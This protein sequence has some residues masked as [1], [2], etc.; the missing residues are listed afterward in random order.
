MKK[1]LK[2]GFTIVE[3]VIVIAVIAILAAVLIPT[4]SNLVRKANVS[5]DTQLVRNLNTA[6]A[7]D[8]KEHKTMQSALDAAEEG[9][10]D[11][12]KIS[13]KISENKILWDSKN[14][15]FCYLN[16]GEIE[17][18]PNSVADEDKLSKDDY[19]LW[20][21]SDVVDTTYSTY[22]YG[23]TGGSTIEATKG[24]D[25]GKTEGIT[26]INYSNDGNEQKVVIRTNGGTLTVKAPL[27]TVNHYGNADK[28]DVQAVA[29]ASYHENGTVQLIAVKEG[30]VKLEGEAD[31]NGVYVYTDNASAGFEDIK[32]TVDLGVEVPKLSRSAVEIADE[33]TKVCT[34][35]TDQAKD[36]YLFNEGIYEQIKTV[37]AGKEITDSS[38]AWADSNVNTA[39]TQTAAQQLANDLN[40]SFTV[41]ET[42]YT[43]TVNI[44]TRELVVT[45]TTTSETVADLNIIA[46][47]TSEAGKTVEEAQAASALKGSGT[48]ADPFLV[49]DYETMQKISDFYNKEF[50]Y[51]EVAIDKTNNGTIDCTNWTPVNMYGCFDGKGVRFVN[52]DE[53][54][55][56]NVK[57][58]DNTDVVVKDFECTFDVLTNNNG[59]VIG[60]V[61]HAETVCNIY[62]SKVYVHGKFIST[63]AASA[64]IGWGNDGNGNYVYNFTDC[65]ADITLASTNNTVAGFVYH[66]YAK[67]DEY[68]INNSAFIGRALV[69]G[70]WGPYQ[71]NAQ[72]AGTTTATYTQEFIDK[73]SL[74]TLFSNAPSVAGTYT[75]TRDSSTLTGNKGAVASRDIVGT[76]PEIGSSFTTTKVAGATKALVTFS[77]GPNPGNLY[78]TFLSENIDLT[79]LSTGD[80]FSTSLVKYYKIAMNGKE[81][82]SGVYHGE[83]PNGINQSINV[84]NLNW[85]GSNGTIHTADVKIVQFDTDE[86]ALVIWKV[87]I[88]YAA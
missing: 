76:L 16:N 48:E 66:P 77:F 73:Y 83:L 32:I 27:D 42:T 75:Y 53:C 72:G 9:G 3:L 29:N 47:A 10:F 62:M 45:N 1:T 26:A 51:F 61:R 41:N 43:V 14:D 6:L 60:C 88:P 28:V 56:L 18:V 65:V 54:L 7:L 40:A 5:S 85:S 67:S 38:A 55:F 36:I 20:I 25:V 59:A 13:S 74:S 49:Y 57:A 79:S 4:F 82:V 87:T 81:V 34:I 21:I 84:Y 17:Y 39:N 80:S 78:S 86:N 58:K 12:A 50:Y 31:V 23:Y 46:E 44:E 11:V 70:T 22:L 71:F 52:L 24:L 37:D 63:Y 68:H 19:K 15:V 8:G 64:Y 69:A 33:G 30:H 2:K 35:V